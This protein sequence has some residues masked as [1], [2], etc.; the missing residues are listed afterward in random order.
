MT[1]RDGTPLEPSDAS[2]PT[3]EDPVPDVPGAVIDAAAAPHLSGGSYPPPHDAVTTRR[4]WIRLGA[5]AGLTRLGVNLVTI[6]PGGFSSLRHWHTGVDEFLIM[7][8]GELTLVEDEAETPMRPGDCAAFPAGNGIGHHLRNDTDA[9]AVFLVMSDTN[10]RD[11]C[12]YPDV[13]LVAHVDG[14]RRWYR[15]RDGTV[16]KE[17]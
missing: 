15:L 11:T 7:R 17:F 9:P 3:V 5:A 14:A 13:D 2:V 16:I 6:A 8:A 4:S 10:E 1:R 12:H